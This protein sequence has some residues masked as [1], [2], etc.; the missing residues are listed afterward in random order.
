VISAWEHHAVHRPAQLLADRGVDV[1]VIGPADDGPFDLEAFRSVLSEGVRL[2]VISAASNVTGELLP[3]GEIGEMAKA[4]GAT[5]MVDAAQIGGWMPIE[6]DPDLF[7]FAGH[8]GPQG[9][10]GIGGLY[11]APHVV[12][13]S[14]EASC[15]IPLDG[16]APECAVMP[17]YCDAGS[18]NRAALAGLAVALQ[19]C[20]PARLL[21]ARELCERF[22]VGALALGMTLHGARNPERRM[23][24]AAV[25][26]A[27]ISP[28]ELAA[29][30]ALAEIYAS[31]GIQCAPL[32]HRTLGTDPTGVLR[33][34][35]GPT[36]RAGDVT[37]I[38]DA[39][40][41][42]LG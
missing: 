3:V 6:G 36:N 16:S 34:S 35:F 29:K 13:R 31:G 15:E 20:N 14:P 39:L 19:A 33:V 37:A 42:I 4:S 9:P 40:R 25:T 38:L 27:G 12:M 1:V 23:P 11:V 28:T 8:K 5:F 10:W 7:A 21:V 17:G 18:V 24:T 2:V 22:V 26:S 32:A 41:E 30:L